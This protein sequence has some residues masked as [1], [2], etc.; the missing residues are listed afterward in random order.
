MPAAKWNTENNVPQVARLLR[1]RRQEK[2]ITLDQLAAASG[3][4]KA[5]ISAIENG[6]NKNPTQQTLSA[7]CA[8][9]NISPSELLNAQ[10]P[11]APAVKNVGVELDPSLQLLRNNN[12]ILFEMLK[13]VVRLSP[14]RQAALQG[15]ITALL[16]D[17]VR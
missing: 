2:R 15:Y 7:L 17:R 16:D 1:M 9:L 13:D 11:S 8:V 10:D 6:R 14:L 5:T 4:C 3:V 12:P